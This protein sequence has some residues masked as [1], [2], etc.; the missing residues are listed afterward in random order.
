MSHLV[1]ALAQQ[2]LRDTQ[3][4]QVTAWE[5]ACVL[6]YLRLTAVH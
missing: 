4:L 3:E 6:P 2:Q 1:I 5:Q